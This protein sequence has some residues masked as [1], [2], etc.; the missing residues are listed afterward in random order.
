[1]ILPKKASARPPINCL[2]ASRSLLSNSFQKVVLRINASETTLVLICRSFPPYIM[3]N[4]LR[5]KK[6]ILYFSIFGTPLYRVAEVGSLSTRAKMAI[7]VFVKR[8]FT[9]FATNASFL[10]VIANL[11]QYN[12][13]YIPPNSAFLAQQQSY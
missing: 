3:S 4:D 5:A 13:E 6:S 1:M 9:F 11:T 12:M 7:T 2:M 8:V 10:C